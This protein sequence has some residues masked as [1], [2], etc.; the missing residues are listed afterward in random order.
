MP[1]LKPEAAEIVR[2]WLREEIQDRNIPEE[3]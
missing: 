1:D 2:K 3:V